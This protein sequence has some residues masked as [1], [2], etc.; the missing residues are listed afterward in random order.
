MKKIPVNVQRGVDLLDE[1]DP[2]W[3]SKINV[4]KLDLSSTCNCVLGQIEGKEN[5][6]TPRFDRYSRRLN[7]I[8]GEAKRDPSKFGFDHRRSQLYENLT[9]AW[10]HVITERQAQL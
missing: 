2:S 7:R 4:D 6:R 1:I 10:K 8:N 9:A 3:P 5:S